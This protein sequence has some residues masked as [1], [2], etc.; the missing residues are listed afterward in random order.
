MAREREALR[1]EREALASRKQAAFAKKLAVRSLDS[2]DIPPHHEIEAVNERVLYGNVSAPNNNNNNNIINNNE[3]MKINHHHSQMSQD[4]TYV[5]KPV[6]KENMSQYFH[7]PIKQHSVDELQTTYEHQHNNDLISP[8]DNFNL[9][10]RKSQSEDHLL[11]HQSIQQ[12]YP[13]PPKQNIID[14][15]SDHVNY[16]PHQFTKQ[17]QSKPHDNNYHPKSCPEYPPSQAYYTPPSPR[18][19]A[20]NKHYY[21]DTQTA[22]FEP[23]QSEPTAMPAI[24]SASQ[25]SWNKQPNYI[26]P[27]PP[28]RKKGPPPPAKPSRIPQ[29]HHLTR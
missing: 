22:Y 25:G 2:L 21:E 26:Q 7:P 17:Y 11:N 27:A 29:Q 6:E 28:I 5:S 24:T 8:S 9:P 10:I 12:P 1:I 3:A 15:A 20:N 16:E 18:Y 23:H 19:D 13:S 4:D 14:R